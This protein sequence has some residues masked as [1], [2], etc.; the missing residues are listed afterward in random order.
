MFFLSPIVFQRRIYELPAWKKIIFKNDNGGRR[1]GRIGRAVIFI[2]IAS[3]FYS[4]GLFRLQSCSIPS[5]NR[6]YRP[7]AGRYSTRKITRGGGRTNQTWPIIPRIAGRTFARRS[8]EYSATPG[9]IQISCRPG[10][11][12]GTPGQPG[13]I[14]I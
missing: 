1:R 4:G 10:G 7:F 2:A 8:S 12:L 3:G 5:G 6:T 13:F 14:E 9:W 11:Q